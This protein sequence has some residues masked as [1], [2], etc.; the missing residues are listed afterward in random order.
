MA[1]WRTWGVPYFI[2]TVSELL[3]DFQPEQQR[4]RHYVEGSDFTPDATV[5]GPLFENLVAMDTGQRWLCV[6]AP[7]RASPSLGNLIFWSCFPSHMRPDVGFKVLFLMVEGGCFGTFFPAGSSE[8]ACG[9]RP[10]PSGRS[11]GWGGAS[12]PSTAACCVAGTGRSS[13][14]LTACTGLLSSPLG[15]LST[16]WHIVSHV[17]LLLQLVER[18]KQAFLWLHTWENYFL[19]YV[20]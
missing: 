19:K 14:R 9:A 5:A 16:S 7:S 4:P 17:K 18:E 11:G 6:P 1:S 20:L 13:S 15:A 3:T 12:V 10:T 8:E 2:F